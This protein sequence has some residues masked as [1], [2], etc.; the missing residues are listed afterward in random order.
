ML[1]GKR[2]FKPPLWS[3]L[4]TI[5]GVVVFVVLGNWQLE[6]AALK[7][8]II[9]KYEQR[10]AL[11]ASDLDVSQ[12]IGEVEFRRVKISGSFHPEHH[13]LVDNQVHGGKAGYLLLTPFRIDGSDKMILVDRGWL[14]LGAS[15]EHYPEIELPLAVDPIEGVVTTY[16]SDGFRY[17]QTDLTGSWPQLIPYIDL[18]ALQQQYSAEL[19]PLIL[20]L[21]PEQP[22]H[23]IRAWQPI[24]AAPEKSQA[25]AV[26]WFSFAALAVLLFIILNLRKVE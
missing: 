21:A 13:F 17:G 12:E 23:Y 16:S 22:G 14:A 6:R 2:E 20:R 15:R 11:P 4:L 3:I 10:L 9:E 19:L 7:A 1:I 26:Q 18:P 25:Y 24:W 8:S 5:C